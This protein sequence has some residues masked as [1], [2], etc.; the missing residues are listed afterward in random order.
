VNAVD[1]EEQRSMETGTIDVSRTREGVDQREQESGLGARLRK[2]RR[3]LG[4]TQTELAD[5][6]GTSQAVI[7]KIENGKSLRPRILEELAAALEVK[8][9]WLMFG[10]EE[11]GELT[12]EAIELA[13]AW[14]RLKE[15]HRT[16]M[17]EAILRIG[18]GR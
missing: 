11:A 4:W 3:A 14:T 2:R 7:Q 18:S 9:A 16:A 13:R 8:P 17:R 15:P 12:D 1:R 6:V 10:V 5:K